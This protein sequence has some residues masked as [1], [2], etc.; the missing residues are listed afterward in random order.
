ME[1]GMDAFSRPAHYGDKGTQ[2]GMERML[3]S[4][5]GSLNSGSCSVTNQLDDLRQIIDLVRA[6]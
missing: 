1:I 5:L 6:S 3:G 4:G 2:R